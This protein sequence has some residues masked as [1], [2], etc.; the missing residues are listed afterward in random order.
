LKAWIS[1][2]N[3]LQQ[4]LHPSKFRRELMLYMVGTLLKGN[5]GMAMLSNEFLQSEIALPFPFMSGTS[6]FWGPGWWPLGMA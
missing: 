1:T 3:C 4:V 6:P 5:I 2:L